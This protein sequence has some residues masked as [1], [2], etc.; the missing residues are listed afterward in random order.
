MNNTENLISE[1]LSYHFKR[2]TKYTNELN[3]I[4]EM[5][6]KRMDGGKYDNIIITNDDILFKD[7]DRSYNWE[8][9]G[10]YVNNSKIFSWGWT[11]P[12]SFYGSSNTTKKIFDFY[13]NKMID[14]THDRIDFFLRNIFLTSRLNIKNNEEL[15]LIFALAEFIMKDSNNFEFIMP[16]KQLLSQDKDD[17]I[18]IYYVMKNKS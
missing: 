8:I 17:F 4:D 15:T 11:L 2:I 13:Y 6:K 14:T 10:M 18:I 9:F 12:K 5:N 3:M 16:R 1:A 7:L